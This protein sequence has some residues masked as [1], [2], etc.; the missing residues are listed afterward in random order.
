MALACGMALAM[1]SVAVPA[2]AQKKS[3]GGG[4]AP[5]G[6]GNTS[7]TSTLDGN[8]DNSAYQ[9]QSDGGGAY[10]DGTDGVSS[11]LETT[12]S[13]G[14]G[15]GDWILNTKGSTTRSVSITLVADPSNTPSLS[16]SSQLLPTRIIVNCS[17]TLGN[18]FLAIL[19]SKS[20]PCPMALNFV[21]KSNTYKLSMG[22]SA[23]SNTT[24]PVEVACSTVNSSG[25]C[26]VWT[27]LPSSTLSDGATPNNIAELD[28]Y[29]GKGKTASWVL[30]GYFDVN[31]SFKVTNP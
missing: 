30:V 9:I 26:D 15:C 24:N 29:Q 17:Q 18:G 21:Y 14:S 27:V 1:F 6:N 10:K 3:K 19:P 7:V 8:I 22:Y 16:F 20:Q 13:C 28:V 31:F 2:L 12:S 23:E 5:G 11:V 4:G 25:V